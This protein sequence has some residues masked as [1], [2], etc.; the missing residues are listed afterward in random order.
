MIEYRKLYYQK[1][2][3]KMITASKEYYQKNKDKCKATVVANHLK[4]FE[5]EQNYYKNYY[6]KNKAYY[7]EYYQKNRL[8]IIERQMS[9]YKKNNKTVATPPPQKTSSVA[10]KQALI[11]SNLAD[12]LVKKE[13]FKKKL[14]A[15]AAENNI[16]IV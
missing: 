5:N 14:A 2:K 10:V 13:A 3:E 1:N 8:Q 16:S 12:L 6:Q 15:E 11:E 4:N 7:K 9:Y